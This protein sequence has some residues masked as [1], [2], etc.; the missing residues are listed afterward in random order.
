MRFDLVDG[1]FFSG[2]VAF[3]MPFGEIVGELVSRR[4]VGNDEGR[5][6]S[7]RDRSVRSVEAKRSALNL[8]FT[9]KSFKQIEIRCETYTY[10]GRKQ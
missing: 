8:T 3:G 5:T 7:L 1:L 10:M 2:S 9:L 4:D 6:G